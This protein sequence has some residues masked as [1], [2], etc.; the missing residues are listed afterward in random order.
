MESHKTFDEITIFLIGPFPPP[1]GGTSLLLRYLYEFIQ[2]QNKARTHTLN[3]LHVRGQGIKGL[4]RFAKMVLEIYKISRKSDVIT[5]H[6]ST[7]AIHIMGSLTYMVSLLTKKPL[8]VRKFAGDDYRDTLGAIGSYVTSFVLRHA[9]LCLFETKS[10]VTMVSKRNIGS[11]KWYPNNR[12]LFTSVDLE[13][14]SKN[15][16]TRFIFIGRVC[17]SKGMRI[18]AEA[19]RKL[20]EHIKINVYGPWSDDLESDLFDDCPLIEYHGQIGPDQIFQVLQQNDASILPTFYKGEGYPGTIIE[21]YFAGLPVIATHWKAI[22][23]IVD[24]SVGIL[25]EPGNANDLA[26][27]MIRLSQDHELYKSLC[28]NT[29]NKAQFFSTEKW[30]DYFVKLCYGL[31]HK[32]S[33]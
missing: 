28:A 3:T 14:S 9:D 12:P 33:R 6:C 30:G 17:E 10:L 7:T 2:E 26:E 8:I 27:A 15:I 24:E 4:I 23:E 32:R 29:R 31:V 11:V 20:S 5:L 21:S 25:V 1:Y 16:C 13:R 22:P 18:L 19:S